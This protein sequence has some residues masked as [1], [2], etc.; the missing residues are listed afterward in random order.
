MVPNFGTVREQHDDTCTR[1]AKQK[2]AQMHA[3]ISS[4][5]MGDTEYCCE[6]DGY[7]YLEIL[8]QP[9]EDE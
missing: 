7:F 8:V 1:W 5:T 9:T 3:R 2:S 6:K 4:Q